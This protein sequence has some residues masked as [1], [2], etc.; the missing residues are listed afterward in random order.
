MDDRGTSGGSRGL[1]PRNSPPAGS[2]ATSRI[3]PRRAIE[4]QARVARSNA[5]ISSPSEGRVGDEA[6][7]WS[8]PRRVPATTKSGSGAAASRAQIG[9]QAMGGGLPAALA[10]SAGSQ[11]RTSHACWS[12]ERAKSS[13]DS[14]ASEAERRSSQSRMNS[15]SDPTASSNAPGAAIARVRPRRSAA[16]GVRSN[17]RHRRGRRARRLGLL[18]GARRHRARSGGSGWTQ[19]LGQPCDWHPGWRVGRCE[20]SPGAGDSLHDKRNALPVACPA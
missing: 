16:T 4:P 5:A 20:R 7:V 8:A 14:A 9:L 1:Q 19:G 3:A 10:G 17:H 6:A 12:A 18:C 13:A 15:P 11:S 2:S